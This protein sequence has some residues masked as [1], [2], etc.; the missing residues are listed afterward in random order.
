LLGNVKIEA[1]VNVV[2]ASGGNGNPF[3]MARRSVALSANSQRVGDA[4]ARSRNSASDARRG[5]RAQEGDTRRSES[6]SESRGASPDNQVVEMSQCWHCGRKRIEHTCAHTRRLRVVK[7]FTL[8]TVVALSRA[9]R[10]CA[11]F[12]LASARCSMYLCA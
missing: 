7:P 12:S 1:T 4:A 2:S 9:C 11:V 3:L 5:S 6:K 8:C 10:V